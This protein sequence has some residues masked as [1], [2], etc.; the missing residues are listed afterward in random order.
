M[1][2]P[3]GLGFIPDMQ[4]QHLIVGACDIDDVWLAINVSIDGELPS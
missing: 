4:G 1:V 3:Q 2:L